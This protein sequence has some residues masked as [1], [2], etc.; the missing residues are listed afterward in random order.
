MVLRKLEDVTMCVDPPRGIQTNLVSANSVF[1]NNKMTENDDI[2][3]KVSKGCLRFM[4][5]LFG[6]FPPLFQCANL[7]SW[8]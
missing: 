7:S 3:D 8:I 5:D 4:V 2:R 1:E 6:V